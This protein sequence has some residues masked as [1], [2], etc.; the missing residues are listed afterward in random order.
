MLFT[1][2]SKYLG[3]GIITDPAKARPEELDSLN[4]GHCGTTMWQEPFKNWEYR[5]TCCDAYVC[6][7][8]VGKGCTPLKMRMELM[9]RG[10]QNAEC[11]RP[12]W[13]EP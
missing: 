10:R 4:C 3:Y 5:C 12:G 6:E 8:C 13:K 7:E 1:R 2:R 11:L 9:E